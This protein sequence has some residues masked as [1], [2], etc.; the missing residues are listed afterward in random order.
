MRIETLGSTALNG[1]RPS[2]TKPPKNVAFD[3]I[4]SIKQG[5][6]NRVFSSFFFP[7]FPNFFFPR[8]KRSSKFLSEREVLD[9]RRIMGILAEIWPKLSG[10]AGK[11]ATPS[12]AKYLG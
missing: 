12:P 11:N 4:Y 5:K 8:V 9:P 1:R 3:Y 6:K 10:R 2:L 7:C